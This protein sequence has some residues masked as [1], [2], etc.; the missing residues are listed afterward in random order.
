MATQ[1]QIDANRENAKKSHGASTQEGREASS[2]NRTT[3]GLCHHSHGLFYFLEDEDRTKYHALREA[4]FAEH[5]PQTETEKILVRHMAQH[6]WLRAR[7]IRLQGTCFLEEG[8]GAIVNPLAFPG[9]ALYL[10]YQTM[11]ERAFFKCLRELQNLREQRRKT[12]IGFESQKLKI[13]AERRAI[14]TLELKK[15]TFELRK[16]ELQIKKVRVRTASAAGT[17]TEP[18]KSDPETSPG[19]QKMAA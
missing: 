2:R 7:A 9:F 19:E 16:E 5:E 17:T 4:L 3:H 18:S 8:E 14:Q 12:E 11:H 15:H 1:A 13:S 6:E 10:R